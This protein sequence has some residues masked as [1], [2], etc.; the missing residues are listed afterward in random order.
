MD[1]T[2]TV[3][4]TECGDYGERLIVHVADEL[5]RVTPE[6]IYASI[7]SSDHDLDQGF[8]DVTIKEFSSAVDTAAW[9]I[10]ETLGRSENFGVLGYIGVSDIRYAIFLLAAI[11]TGYQVRL[12]LDCHSSLSRW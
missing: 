10:E 6:R 11:K 4:G 2:A 7:S 5:A 12:F 1:Q 3:P 8:Q 9:W